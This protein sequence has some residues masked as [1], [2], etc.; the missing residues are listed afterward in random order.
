MAKKASIDKRRR[1]RALEAKRDSL[2]EAQ[3]KNKTELAK[4]RAELA[5]ARKL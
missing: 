5:T 3:T 4:V 1:V 2:L